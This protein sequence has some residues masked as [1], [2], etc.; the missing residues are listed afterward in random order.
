MRKETG[1]A[2]MSASGTL[3]CALLVW[4]C[5][6]LGLVWTPW[7]TMQSDTGYF[8][9][10]GRSLARGEGY[11]IG[12]VRH[13]A[14]PPVFPL[15]LAA[16]HSP[17]RSDFRPEKLAVVGSFWLFSQ[18]FTG[19]RRLGLTVLMA[20]S[21]SL[22]RR[23]GY[24]LTDVPGLCF[25]VLFVAAWNAFWRGQKRH[26]PIGVVAT[27]ALAASAL[28][29][30]AGLFFYLGCAAWLARLSLWRSDR[31]RCLTGA[32]L[33]VVFGL[34]P[35]LA[36]GLWVRS[37]AE[38]GSASYA[39]FLRDDVLSGHSPF[40]AEGLWTL[41][42]RVPQTVYNQ[43]RLATHAVAGRGLG[44]GRGG[45]A[46]LLLPPVLVGLC[47]R[48]RR[49]EAQDYCFIGFAALMALWPSP[50]GP[51]LWLPAVPL[52]L[53][54]LPEGAERIAGWGA[55]VARLGERG[56]VRLGRTLLWGGAALVLVSMLATDIP[57]VR[58]TWVPAAEPIGNVVLEGGQLDVARFVR[59]AE[60][61]PPVVAYVRYLGVVPAIRGMA[62]R[63]ARIPFG[64]DSDAPSAMRRL[65]EQGATHLA[66]GLR[67]ESMS[68]RARP[69]DA[70]KRLVAALPER[71][72]L[73]KS[74]PNVLIYEIISGGR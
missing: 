16:V 20:L 1:K 33:F 57:A 19:W 60:G 32:A 26:W 3:A 13:R 25:A 43:V 40:S 50:Q 61:H 59:D 45:W 41:V 23:T 53:G 44:L 35:V 30:L 72:R 24:L 31:R 46:I 4:A 49:P 2:L 18:R 8:M 63:V 10:L 15:M 34:L 48:M 62:G 74:T 51:R 56:S 28:T 36:W 71:F 58:D 7:F 22:V 14:Y 6:V 55:R 29:R 17:S 37:T 73:A 38:A 12:G 21:P 42:K 27:A 11:A 64:A 70:A 69:N 68:V 54:Y 5:T 52:M 39:D 65:A 66:V 67:S 47:A 9:A